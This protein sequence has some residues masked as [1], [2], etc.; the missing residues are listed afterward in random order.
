MK[1]ALNKL[2]LFSLLIL[3]AATI[4]SCSPKPVDLVKAYQGAYNSH[5]LDGLMSLF[6]DDA[7]FEV[8]G[9][10][11]LKGKEDVRRVA[12]YDSALNIHMTISQFT[13]RGDTVWCHLAETND[14]LKTAGIGEATY[15]AMFVIEDGLIKLIRGESTPEIDKALNQ[16]L[17][18]LLEW[19]SKERPEQLAEMTPEGKFAYNAE[20]AKKSLALLREWQEA[21]KSQ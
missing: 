20:N 5:D 10:F 11:V 8:V 19:A 17:E 21:T 14:W 12:E 16:V 6:T 3:L 7:A 2:G 13:T 1:I 9:Q 18:P 15:S 4:I